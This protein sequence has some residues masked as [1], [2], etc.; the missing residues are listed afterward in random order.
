MKYLK[1]ENI[2]LIPKLGVLDSRSKADVGVDFFGKNFKLPI[3][4]ANMKAVINESLSKWLS[5][6]DYFYIM[7][8]FDLDLFNFVKIANQENWKTI[9]I[10]LG[11]KNEDKELIKKIKQSSLRVDFVTID[12]AHGHSLA[13]RE[14]ISFIK[15]NLDCIIIAGNVASYYSILDLVD[16]G[17]DCV[18]I[19]VGQGAPC[20]TKDKTGFTAPMFTCVKEC[21]KFN[22]SDAFKK[23]PLI[24]DGGIKCN[25]DIA[26]SIVAGA[27][28]AMAG[29]LFSKC[30]DSPA[31]NIELN[32][33]I[34]KRYFGSASALNKGHNNH[35]EG[36]EKHLESNGMTYKQKMIEIE[37]DLQ[38]SVSYAG[39]V[40]LDSLNSVS[41]IEV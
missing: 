16:W 4:P 6:N 33:V 11:V 31:E 13:M 8:R 29:S 25:G 30:T 34:Y 39:G 22:S 14:M 27:T 20:S 12:I 7:H 3:I 5:E 24:A 37:Q 15:D 17:A 21:S 1:Y 23:V 32:G 19:G 9:S 36:F 18:K 28:M 26:K 35:I 40:S 10:S 38:S 2:S 41:Y